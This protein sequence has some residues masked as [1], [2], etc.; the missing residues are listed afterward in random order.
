[1][2]EALLITRND[3]VKFTAMNGNVDSDNFIQ[4]IKISQDIH[5]Q[6]YLGTDLLEK[7]KSEIILAASGIPTA[8][9]IS[10]QGTGYTTGTAI[11]TTSATGTGLKLNITAA[12]GLITAATINT[13]GTG[14]TVGSTATVTGGTNGAVTI[15]SIYTIPTDYNN[16]LV[17]YVKPMLIHW[18]MVE[19]LP[20][21][22]YTIANKGVYKHNS[23]NATNV[24]K[25]EID[26]LIEKERSIAQHY[27]ERFID[28]ISFNN[29]LFPEYNSNSNG[30]MYPDTNNNYT[31]W[32]L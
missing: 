20:F 9:T 19:Y 30:D 26:F 3:V 23:E 28:Y 12:G 13:A 31:G 17:T 27:T 14:Y 16:L 10:N 21:A 18:A 1:M 25:V 7:L 29:D 32:Y 8:I 11:N 4:Y 6:N 22:A 2:A 24:E 5:I 15:S